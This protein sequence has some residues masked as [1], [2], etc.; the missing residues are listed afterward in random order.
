M[1][2]ITIYLLKIKK[3]S[4]LTLFLYYGKTRNRLNIKVSLKL[5]SCRITRSLIKEKYRKLK[6][7][8]DIKRLQNDTLNSVNM[9][10]ND[11]E[12]IMDV[13]IKKYVD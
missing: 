13:E 10:E 7:V 9:Y 1:E 2:Q 12:L 8:Y 4:F 6:I 5:I 3:K 11:R